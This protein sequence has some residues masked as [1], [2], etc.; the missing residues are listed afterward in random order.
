VIE[1]DWCSDFQRIVLGNALTKRALKVGDIAIEC[2]LETS[3]V[4][5]AL[6]RDPMHFHFFASHLGIG[7]WFMVSYFATFRP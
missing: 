1:A 6:R 3:L 7:E 5:V 2:P 4:T